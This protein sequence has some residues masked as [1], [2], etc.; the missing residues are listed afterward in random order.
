MGFL[1]MTHERTHYM[2]TTL[3]N[4][5]GKRALIT[6]SSQGLGYAMAEG[7]G[8][9]GATLIL[10]GRNVEKLE[11][12]AKALRRKRLKVHTVAFD[13]S[14]EAAVIAGVAQAEKD[15]GSIDILVNNA[16]INSR[17]PIE[18]FDSAEWK[19]I[20]DVNLNGTF[21]VSKAVGAR[22]IKRKR[23]KVINIASLLAEAAR[24]AITPYTASKG[25]VKMLTK[26]MA[27][28]WAEHNIQVNAI[29]PGYF[30]TEMNKPLVAD[31]K[32]DAWVKSK[33]PAGRWG[34]PSELVGAAVF[35][36]SKASDFVTGQILY[37]DG[38]WLAN[39]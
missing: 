14:D 39:L 37:V 5:K 38:G 13:V 3:F 29:G 23:G 15:A 20:M 17:G 31:K 35:F 9:A 2:S 11:K 27:V 24:P 21:Y 34:D 19:R 10:N 36:A 16:G 8:K 7:M 1:G 26:G 30:V 22:M 32:F 18:E 28:E 4:L 12:A 6:G 33:A 25:A